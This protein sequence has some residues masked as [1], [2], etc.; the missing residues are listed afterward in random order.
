MGVA[1]DSRVTGMISIFICMH[2]VKYIDQRKLKKKLQRVKMK[3]KDFSQIYQLKF[4][5]L[6][7]QILN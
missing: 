7:I 1:L 3:I 4:V 2:G 5:C 6:N